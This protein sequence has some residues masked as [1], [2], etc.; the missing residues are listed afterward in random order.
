VIAVCTAA[1]AYLT[2]WS[3]AQNF[4]VGDVRRGPAR[5]ARVDFEFGLTEVQLGVVCHN[6]VPTELSQPT[7]SQSP[8]E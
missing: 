2:S 8:D 4:Q 7:G 5:V 6:G 3:P 1:G